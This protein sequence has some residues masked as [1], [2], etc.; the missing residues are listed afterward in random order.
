VPVIIVA[1][2][3]NT[4]ASRP[5]VAVLLRCNGF[6]YC[7]ETRYTE[8]G[9]R[10]VT[11]HEQAEPI[12]IVGIGC[13]LPGGINALGEYWRFLMG[14]H[15]AIG[16]IPASRWEA[17]AANPRFAGALRAVT[18]RGAFLD[19]AAGFDAQFFGVSPR[20]AELIDPQQRLALETSWEAL[21]DAGIPPHTLAGTDA[22]VFMGAGSDDYGRQMLED[23]PGIEAWTGIGSSLCAVANRVSY[24][25]DL[26][27]PSLAVDTACSSSLVAIHLACQSLR[28]SESTIALAGGVHLVAA[29]GLSMVLDAAGATSPD[30]RSKSFDASADGYGRG[31]GVGVLVLKRLSDAVR[32]GDH[33]RA[34]V[35]GSAVNQD[36][37][38]NGIMAPSGDAQEYV[39][40]QALRQAAVDPLTVDYVEAHG[41]GTRLGD[42]I[43]VAALARVFGA[44]RPADAPCLIGSVK[45]NIGHLEAGAGVAGVIKA[46]L[47]LEHATIPPTAG[48]TEL[49]PDIPWAESGLLVTTEPVP[50][51]QGQPVRRAGVSGFGYGGTVS[52]VLLE[53]A[54]ADTHQPT[55]TDTG[56]WLFVLSAAS[57]E[58]VCGEAATLA[59]WLAG[60][61]ADTPLKDV[62]HTLLEHRSHLV[63]RA[64]VVAGDRASL[65][66][67]LEAVA[68][69]ESSPMVATGRVPGDQGPGPVWVFSGHG[70]QWVGM[71]RDLLTAEPAFREAIAEIDPV[72][73]QEAGFSPLE[74]LLHGPLEDVDVIQ[75]MIFAVQA[76]LTAVLRSRGLVPAAIIGHSVGEVAAA[77]AA[78][79]FD[80]ETGARLVCRRSA[81]LRKA[82][83]G[84]AMA[85]VQLPFDD[86]Q[87]RLAG[88]QDVVAAIAA[89]PASTVISGSP[90]GVAAISEEWSAKDVMVRTVASTVAFHGPQMDPLLDDLVAALA[91]L[92]PAEPTVPLYSTALTDPRSKAPRDGHYWAA[93]LRQPVRLDTAV[94]AAAEDGHRVFIE[95]SAHPVVVHSITETLTDGAFV[96]GTVRRDRPEVATLLAN[97]GALH[98]HGAIAEPAKLQQPGRRTD[99]PRR[100]WQHKQYWRKPSGRYQTG[101]AHDVDS[102]TLLGA[103]V[104]V[105]GASALEIWQTHIDQL[106]LPY[107]GA[108]PIHG[109]EVIPAAVLLNTFLVAGRTRVLTDVQLKV[110]VAVTGEHAIQVVRT[111]NMARLASRRLDTANDAAGWLTHSVTS[112]DG[113]AAVD[114]DRPEELPSMPTG[115]V[116]ERLR[117]VGV[118]DVGFPWQ[119]DSLAGAGGEMVAEVRPAP[120][121]EPA[122]IRWPSLLDAVLSIAPL[123]FPNDQT[124]RMP[125]AIKALD[126]AETL[127]HRVVVHVRLTQ[128]DTTDVLITDTE[129]NSLGTLAGLRFG[130]LD[131]DPGA[132]ISPQRLVHRLEW[133]PVELTPDKRLRLRTIALVG[134]GELADALANKLTAAGLRCLRASEPGELTDLIDDLGHGDAVLVLPMTG[135]VAQRSAWQLASTAQLLIDRCGSLPPRLWAVTHKAWAG[136]EPA[137]VAQSSMWGL[138]RV[139]AGEHPELAA[140]LVDIDADADLENLVPL[141]R[142]QPEPDGYAL[143]RNDIAAARLVPLTG[144]PGAETMRCRANGTYLI[145]GG[146]GALG[147][148]VA[149]WLA[150]R[151]AQR[152]V[153]TGRTALPPR[154]DWDQVTD[155]QLAR[156]IDAVRSL[157]AL[158]VT[159]RVLAFDIADKKA[160]AEA[161]TSDALGLPPIQ[162]IVHA[163][164][165]LDD[166]MLGKL[167]EDSLK[168][169]MRPK[170][171]GA[172][173]LDELFPPGSV[174]FFVLFS[175]IGFQLGLTGQA[176][177]ASANAFLDALARQRRAGGH[178]DT[179]SF[180]WTSWRGMGMAASDFVDAELADR[181]VG[182]ISPTDAFG[183]WQF[184]SGFDADYVAVLRAVAA[185]GVTTLPILR[186]ISVPADAG[187]SDDGPV[188]F[189]AELDPAELRAQLLGEVGKQIEAELKLSAAKLDIHRPLTELGLDSI[190]TQVIRRGLE[191]RLRLSLPATL[192]WNHPTAAAVADYL[193]TQ[194]GRDTA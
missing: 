4:G 34:V 19:D 11:N 60:E 58:G 172:L 132:S 44:D 83:G 186:E 13:R 163:A 90:D 35:R 41:T 95:L 12:A 158:G 65:I 153:L 111:D 88:Q 146:L 30:G 156:R 81:L 123:A 162:G 108:H 113:G 47:A 148:E 110:P 152:L 3:R 16:D 66:A 154:N 49:N 26:R 191:K 104:T 181:G 192:I 20:E 50:W 36:G 68:A 160:A 185:S 175:S 75:P 169:V 159:V 120:G 51:P 144:E 150:S 121:D 29:P 2:V 78:G 99:L 86:V 10:T 117:S 106:S 87:D 167:D 94:T 187:E 107:P 24:V 141:L 27:G 67:G 166:R 84:G 77:V 73:E 103:P 176:S 82:A 168:T 155:P 69:G 140:R 54:P 105:A 46:V 189:A 194:L 7:A 118:A 174:D 127:P 171:D 93:N 101:G 33:I 21:E 72:F 31:E 134:D 32:D 178:R 115:A 17:Y 28:A 55:A 53:Q 116:T 70:S 98:C 71:G 37:R 151:G 45:A 125:A 109:V 184:A 182:D 79:V 39:V 138:I 177:Y 43:E 131:G 126:L 42:P 133:M 89:S 22:G 180:A 74:V 190:M 136:G 128:P 143:R 188:D 114:F 97:L 112:L 48:L 179:T 142:S 62:A 15:E 173:V 9:R 61:G 5:H 64:A 124:L 165:V 164:G 23:L 8:W 149:T 147:I 100:T 85:M 139:I 122:A 137:D 38:T 96:T 63:N 145:T 119:I 1:P 56:P 102:Y 80:L 91:D 59:K 193:A 52:H 130:T 183:A 14:A 6:S 129:G 25:L 40:R 157:E 135:A 92:P 170:V 76:G 57:E 161:L 18:R